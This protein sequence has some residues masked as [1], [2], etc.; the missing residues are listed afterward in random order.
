MDFLIHLVNRNRYECHVSA[1]TTMPNAA[2][3][4]LSL[5]TGNIPRAQISLV[6]IR[7]ESA[8]ISWSIRPPPHVQFVNA[9]SDTHRQTTTGFPETSRHS[10]QR[11]HRSS[12]RYL[13]TEASNLPLLFSSIHHITR[14]STNERSAHLRVFIGQLHRHVSRDLVSAPSKY[15]VLLPFFTHRTVAK[16]CR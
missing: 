3:N 12:R 14:E 5:A 1:C 10:S 13:R 9:L 6:R 15:L 2:H 8:K 7:R 4:V 16:T 11:F